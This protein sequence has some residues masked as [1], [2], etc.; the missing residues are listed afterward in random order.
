MLT[1]L[2]QITRM[3]GLSIQ[4]VSRV[5]GSNGDMCNLLPE[6]GNYARNIIAT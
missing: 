6:M 5:F 3:S 4:T 2:W 1:I